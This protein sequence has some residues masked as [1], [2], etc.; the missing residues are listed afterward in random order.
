MDISLAALLGESVYNF[1]ELLL[2]PLVIY[3]R[4]I[5]ICTAYL[6]VKE[7]TIR[8]AADFE[9]CN[10]LHLLQLGYKLRA[11]NGKADH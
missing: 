11:M 5:L 6:I 4:L 3:L 2:H 7:R 10:N 1:G 9:L 8:N